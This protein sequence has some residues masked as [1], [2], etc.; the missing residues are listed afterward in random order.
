[1]SAV[2]GDEADPAVVADLSVG[3]GPFIERFVVD[4]SLIR[5]DINKVSM[6]PAR[7]SVGPLP[8]RT[9][10]GLAAGCPAPGQ[11]KVSTNVGVLE[12]SE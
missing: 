5:D 6:G 2:Y 4:Q 10:S 1:M 3:F 11:E 7:Q 9:T 12:T 8:V